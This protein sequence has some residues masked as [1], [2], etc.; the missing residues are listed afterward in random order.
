MCPGKVVEVHPG[1]LADEWLAT[2]T[3]EQSGRKLP[4]SKRGPGHPESVIATPSGPDDRMGPRLSVARLATLS[5][6]G[7]SPKAATA[8]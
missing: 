2:F 4:H 8:A 3:T 5:Q 6:V 7:D 1:C